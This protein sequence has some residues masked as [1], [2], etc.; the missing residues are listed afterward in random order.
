MPDLIYEIVQHD[1]GW[2]YKVDGVLSEP[3]ATHAGALAAARA[4]AEEQ[5]LPGHRKLSST[6]MTRANGTQ[7]PPAVATARTPS[8]RT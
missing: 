4:A 7:K 2:A 1:V 6:R 3:F 5:E 8:S